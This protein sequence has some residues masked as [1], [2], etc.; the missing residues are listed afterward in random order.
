MSTPNS[1][2]QSSS[3]PDDIREIR[4]KRHKETS[5]ITVQVTEEPAAV[6]GEPEEPGEQE[7]SLAEIL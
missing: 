4:R 5:S 2:P 7:E 3:L 1:K 6:P